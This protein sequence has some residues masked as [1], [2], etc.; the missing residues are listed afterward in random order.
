MLQNLELVVTLWSCKIAA[1]LDYHFA[2]LWLVDD[3][4]MLRGDPGKTFLRK[5]TSHQVVGARILPSPRMTSL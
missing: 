3:Q 2:P 4:K 1:L 5:E